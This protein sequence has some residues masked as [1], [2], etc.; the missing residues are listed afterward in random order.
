MLHI[1]YQETQ[2][3]GQ[4][5]SQQHRLLTLPTDTVVGHA[6]AQRALELLENDKAGQ[7]ALKENHQACFW[8]VSVRDPV[9]RF[10]SKFYFRQAFDPKAQAWGP[11]IDD[12]VRTDPVVLRRFPLVKT[13][14]ELGRLLQVLEE[15]I[16]AVMVTERFDESLLV[17]EEEGVVSRATISNYT[18]YGVTL[19]RPKK[20]ALEPDVRE[21]IEQVLALDIIFYE[22]AKNKLERSIERFGRQRMEARLEEMRKQ[23][24]ER[25]LSCAEK[26]E[27]EGIK[28]ASGCRNFTDIQQRVQQSAQERG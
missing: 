12:F 21:K 22:A 27:L 5:F 7:R 24:A 9:E 6:K 28:A 26:E 2:R 20:D 8:L 11:S 23:R 1:L 3:R 16:D 14:K 15:E 18:N 13:K 17:L 19:G 4:T 25:P 10:I